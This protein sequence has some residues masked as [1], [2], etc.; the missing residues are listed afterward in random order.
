MAPSGISQP[1]SGRKH[2]CR[3]LLARI[4]QALHELPLS[5]AEIAV[6]A[7]KLAAGLVRFHCGSPSESPFFDIR[8]KV[9]AVC[10]HFAAEGL[11]LPEYVH[12]A[13]RNPQLFVKA[14]ASSIAN[15]EAVAHR[16]QPDGLTLRSYLQAAL[17]APPLFAM[18]AATVIA[19]IEAVVDHFAGDGLT[20]RQYLQAVLKQPQLF[21]QSPATIIGH[22]GYLI[23]MYRQGLLT[24]P[25]EGQAPPEQPLAPLFAFLSQ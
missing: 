9:T 5:K 2:D 25:G 10:E 4:R 11:T 8:S 24:F 1:R 19:N 23:E 13:R 18:S 3:V 21:Y 6:V 16:F 7:P 14:P 17:R 15:V 22:L 12:A 20:F